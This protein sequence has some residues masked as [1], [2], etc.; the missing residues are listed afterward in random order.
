MVIASCKFNFYSNTKKLSALISV[1]CGKKPDTSRWFRRFTQ[2][3]SVSC[4]NINYLSWW[5]LTCWILWNVSC[6]VL[7]IFTIL[8]LCWFRVWIY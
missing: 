6:F 7:F 2:I 8:L 4:W 3:S 5:L 1:I